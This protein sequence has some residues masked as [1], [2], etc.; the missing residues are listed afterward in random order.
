MFWLGH[1]SFY[2][3]SPAG[4][5]LVTDPFGPDVLPVV[6]VSADIITVSH[7]HFDHNHIEAVK[8]SPE[9]WRGLASG[10]K[11][12]AKFDKTYKDVHAYTVAT[13]HDQAEG[14]K[15]GKNAV[16]VLEIGEL[17]LAHLGDLGHILNEE[18]VKQIGHVDLLMVPVGGNFTINAEQAWQVVEALNPRVVVPMHYLVKG[19]K[20]FP[21]APVSVF[22]ARH[23][24]VR[25]LGP[26]K[27]D[28][29]QPLP[30]TMEIWVLEPSGKINQ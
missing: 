4:V 29:G 27:I 23:T 30:S 3:E 11:E 7:E 9:V 19:I 25:N 26:V 14:A 12:W 20:D 24:N 1:A 18:Q 17:R 21:I 8:G 10:G 16:F 6:E 15:R 2:L 13:Y 28:L 22:T 5:R